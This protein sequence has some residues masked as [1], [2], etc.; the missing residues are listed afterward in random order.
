MKTLAEE[1][2]V[3][4]GAV[5]LSGLS[6]TRQMLDLSFANKKLADT[7]PFQVKDTMLIIS[8]HSCP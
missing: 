6:F 3:K 7:F 8:F 2:K 5:K 1:S 4:E